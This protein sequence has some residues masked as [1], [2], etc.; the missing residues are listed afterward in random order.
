LFEVAVALRIGRR[1]VKD[2]CATAHRF[3]ERGAIAEVGL[4]PSD[5]QIADRPH[6]A[7]PAAHRAHPSAAR[8]RCAGDLPAYET[9]VNQLEEV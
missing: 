5:R 2:H 8:E 9:G 6:C 7:W 4:R 3:D 1:R